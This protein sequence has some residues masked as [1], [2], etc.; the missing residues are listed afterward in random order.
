MT[1]FC[2][3]I[4][5]NT[6]RMNVNK[7]QSRSK[8]RLVVTY[9]ILRN[10]IRDLKLFIAYLDSLLNEYKLGPT[11]SLIPPLMHMVLSKGII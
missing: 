7:S 10:I 11:G 3:Y 9:N 1:Y 8:L 2:S 4:V 6:C 5:S